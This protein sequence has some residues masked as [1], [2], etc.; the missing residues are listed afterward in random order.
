MFNKAE[1][2]NPTPEELFDIASEDYVAG[3]YE[4]AV[5][6]FQ[7]VKDEYPLSK[8][9]VLAELKVADCHYF[10]ENYAEA[11]QAYGDFMNLHPTNKDVPYVMYQLGMCRFRQI[12]TIDRDQTDTHNARKAFERLLARFPESEY[13]LPAERNVREC[14]RRIAEHE[15]YVGMFYFRTKRYAAALKRFEDL[16]ASYPHLGLD[17][18]VERF[19]EETKRLLAEQQAK[20]DTA[21]AGQTK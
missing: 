19:T 11:E 8:E 21:A 13:T 7:R 2:A 18:K 5:E 9:A 15:F 3:K 14:K 16:A 10:E 20:K 4:K 12:T 6:K 1:L 17:Y